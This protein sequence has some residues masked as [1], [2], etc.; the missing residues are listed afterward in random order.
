[1]GEGDTGRP[2]VAGSGKGRQEIAADGGGRLKIIAAVVIVK[3]LPS[4]VKPRQW[5]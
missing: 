4:E 5:R 3:I 2:G 1:M